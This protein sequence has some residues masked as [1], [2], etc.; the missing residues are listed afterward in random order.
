MPRKRKQTKGPSK[1]EQLIS[2]LKALPLAASRM[3]KGDVIKLCEFTNKH[4]LTNIDCQSCLVCGS[5]KAK[6]IIA[7]INDLRRKYNLT[8]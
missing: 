4:K 2:E 5:K 1:E 6:Q 7:I 3:R 8:R